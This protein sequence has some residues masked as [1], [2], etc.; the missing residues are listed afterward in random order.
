MKK[1]IQRIVLII[2][3]LV[4]SLFVISCFMRRN[5]SGQSNEPQTDGDTIIKENVRVITSEMDADELPVEVTEDKLVF[6]KNPKYKKGDVIVSGMIEKA[7]AGFIRRVIDAEKENN[8][9]VFYTEPALLTDVFEKAHIVKYM[10]LTE[11]GLEEVSVQQVDGLEVGSQQQ[12]SFRNMSMEAD[13]STDQMPEVEVKPSSDYMFG[14]EVEVKT[15]MVTLSGECGVKAWFQIDMNIDHGNIECSMAIKSAGEADLSLKFAEKILGA[16]DPV[17]VDKIFFEKYLP[18]GE[19]LVGGVPL[20]FTNKIEMHAE[21]SAEIEGTIGFSYHA[22]FDAT[23]GFQ[24]DSKTGKVEELNEFNPKTPGIEFKAIEVS[25]NAS[26]GVSAHLIVKLYGCSGIDV[27][28]GVDGEVDGTVKVSTKTSG[29]RDIGALDMGIGPEITGTLAVDIPVIAPGLIEQPLFTVNL[30]KFWEYH[31]PEEEKIYITRWGE[32]HQTKYPTFQFEVPDG[33]KVVTEELDS[34]PDVIREHV[35]LQN[36]EGLTVEYWDFPN[37]LGGHGHAASKAEITK[38]ADSDFEPGYP[39]GTDEDY[40]YLGKFMV[41]KV[42]GIAT[43]MGTIED[44][45]SP[46]DYTSYAVLPE[47]FEKETVYVGRSGQ[48]ETFSFQYPTYHVFMAHAPE[49]Q[50]TEEQEAEVIAILKSFKVTNSAY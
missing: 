15:E 1:R 22:S 36:D 33:W 3:I 21:A 23:Q 18:K 7:E 17:E 32:A 35:E 38:A 20:V 11:N 13:T 2:V 34:A 46:C 47:N 12:G 19:F 28:V 9:F 30:P 40:S 10:Q 50:F 31:W 37:L 48:L 39:E 8:Q 41:A 5:N 14:A 6:E 49:G 26:A 44:D 42:H 43:M 16:V 45:W 24:Y 27:A 25:A 4:I 29:I